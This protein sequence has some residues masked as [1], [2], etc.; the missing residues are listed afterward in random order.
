MADLGIRERSWGQCVCWAWLEHF[1]AS[2]QSCNILLFVLIL[3]ELEGWES[4]CPISQ[5]H[6]TQSIMQ[7][8]VPCQARW[9]AHSGL[10]HVSQNWWSLPDP[11]CYPKGFLGG[12]LGLQA[13][14]RRMVHISGAWCSSNICYTDAL[15]EGITRSE[16]SR[17]EVKVNMTKSMGI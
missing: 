16:D 10:S 2:F 8:G 6:V 9:D 13:K 11:A 15:R 14:W 12:P 4:R 5:A 1:H 3:A 7:N 17:R